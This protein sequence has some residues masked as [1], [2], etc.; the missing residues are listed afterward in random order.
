MKANIL[1]NYLV[2]INTVT[3][4]AAI[5]V[6]YSK[7]IVFITSVCLIEC[8]H[9]T[10][11]LN[12]SVRSVRVCYLDHHHRVNC[13]ILRNSFCGGMFFL[14]TVITYSVCVRYLIS[15]LCAAV[16]RE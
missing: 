10:K 5:V 14:A 8:K 16:C 3:I 9:T 13:Y 12:I 11:A 4:L 2:I 15:F 6:E 1:L 7:F